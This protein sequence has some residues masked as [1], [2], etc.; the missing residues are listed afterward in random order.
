MNRILYPFSLLHVV[1][2]KSKHIYDIH[3]Y[4]EQNNMQIAFKYCKLRNV[5]VQL[6]FRLSN[7][8]HKLEFQEMLHIVKIK[9]NTSF[10]YLQ[11]LHVQCNL[12]QIFAV[13]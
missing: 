11:N 7:K 6:L 3:V 13:F 12:L 4:A 8:Y 1:I 2:S 10:S 5:C 9:S